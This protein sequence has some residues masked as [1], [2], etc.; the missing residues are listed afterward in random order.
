[1]YAD[2]L[3]DCIV[4]DQFSLVRLLA[5]VYGMLM[6]QIGSNIVDEIHVLI[7]AA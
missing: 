5:H 2:A 6:W 3:V 4:L 1:M 7:G